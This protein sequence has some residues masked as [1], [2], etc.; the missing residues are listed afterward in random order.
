MNGTY[1]HSKYNSQ[2]PPRFIGQM[3]SSCGVGKMIGLQSFDDGDS[4]I[5]KCRLGYGEVWRSLG[6]AGV[7]S[8]ESGGR[9]CVRAFGRN[10]G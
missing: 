5:Q 4:G 7:S 9:L 2:C 6:L 10:L 3:S 1:T 8:L